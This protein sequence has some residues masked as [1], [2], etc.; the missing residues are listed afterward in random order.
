MVCLYIFV[1]SYSGIFQL[2][3]E[4]TG[5]ALV[6]MNLL[7]FFRQS[8]IA[9]NTAVQSERRVVLDEVIILFLWFHAGGRPVPNGVAQHSVETKNCSHVL[10]ERILVR[11]RVGRI[12]LADDVA[13]LVVCGIIA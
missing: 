1:L 11:N 5:S 6:A 2:K 13:C 8:G 4:T 3:I 12:E 9:F 7:Y 10:S